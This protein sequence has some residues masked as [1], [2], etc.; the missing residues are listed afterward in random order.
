VRCISCCWASSH[1]MVNG[2]TGFTTSLCSFSALRQMISFP[3]RDHNSHGN[4]ASLN[5]MGRRRGQPSPRPPAAIAGSD[6]PGGPSI[7]EPTSGVKG[8]TSRKRQRSGRKRSPY[9]SKISSTPVESI[10]SIGEPPASRRYP[11]LSIPPT[12][13]LLR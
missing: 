11:P 7:P 9:P 12:H 13:S 4:I 1:R 2:R 8:S 10:P 5:L 3:R 6:P